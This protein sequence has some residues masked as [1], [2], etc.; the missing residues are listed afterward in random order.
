MRIHA[1]NFMVYLAVSLVTFGLTL[2]YSKMVDDEAS[3]P[4]IVLLRT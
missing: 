2:A 4:S 3:I 1:V